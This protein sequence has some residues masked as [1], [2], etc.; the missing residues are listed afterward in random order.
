MTDNANDT[1]TSGGDQDPADPPIATLRRW[2][3]QQ[4]VHQGDPAITA[5][6]SEREVEAERALAQRIR[7]NERLRRWKRVQADSDAEDR[8]LRTDRAIGKA[9]VA[10]L[11]TARKALAVQRRMTSAH[12]RLAS[13]YRHRT[14]SLVTLAGVVLAGMLWSATNVQHNIAPGGAGDPLYWFSYLVEVMIS[15]CLAV[16]MIGTNKVGEYGI[17]DDRRMVAAAELALLGLTVALNTYPYWHQG[18]TMAGVGVHAVPPVMVG[19]ALMTHHGASVR[20]GQAIKIQADMVPGDN[21]P[22][23]TADT[24]SD[25]YS[26]F[27]GGHTYEEHLRRTDTPADVRIADTPTLSAI[28]GNVR[29]SLRPRSR[30]AAVGLRPHPRLHSAG[31]RRLQ[32][33]SAPISVE[34]D[35][36]TR[37]A[38]DLDAGVQA[39]ASDLRNAIAQTVTGPG[40][41]SQ[42]KIDR[43][44]ILQIAEQ[45]PSWSNTRIADAYGC[46]PSAIDKIFRVMP[47]PG[48][49]P[50]PILTEADREQIAIDHPGW[51]DRQIADA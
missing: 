15:A 25:A 44:R 21:L 49:D 23:I 24:H 4:L 18:L 27:S 12:A 51:S 30:N 48:R 40:P 33:G 26:G 22:L 11:L 17:T 3:Q 20:Y 35:H 42:W 39:V 45:H 16:I 28:S 29:G 32:R 6:W 41:R 37:P 2:A 1:G 7:D 46:S 36:R 13:L 9:D 14:W 38:T 19:V 31:A 47:R 5:A 34:A 43:Q 8:A 10:D 50:H